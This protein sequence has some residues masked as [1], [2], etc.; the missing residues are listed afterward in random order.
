MI[1]SEDKYLDLPLVV[2]D[3]GTF[4]YVL[5]SLCPSNTS[6]GGDPVYFIRGDSSCEYH[7]E[8]IGHLHQ[9]LVKMGCD[10]SIDFLI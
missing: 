4:K 2:I 8:V 10:P 7:V 1:E 9:R 6:S 5:L 3:E